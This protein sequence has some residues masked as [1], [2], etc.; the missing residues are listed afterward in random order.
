MQSA[1]KPKSF[2]FRII[3]RRYSDKS[4]IHKKLVEYFASNPT[5]KHCQVGLQKIFQ[6]LPHPKFKLEQSVVDEMESSRESL[7]PLSILK[8]SPSIRR[9]HES[10]RKSRSPSPSTGAIAKEVQR[11]QSF[12]EKEKNS[13]LTVRD[14]LNNFTTNFCQSEFNRNPYRSVNLIEFS[15]QFSAAITKERDCLAK[16]S[17]RR[18][19]TMRLKIFSKTWSS[20]TEACHTLKAKRLIAKKSNCSSTLSCTHFSKL[21]KGNK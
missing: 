16:M 13:L 2:S 1:I 8:R 15:F 11:L 9:I 17:G 12:K 7:T 6:L 18:R 5:P 3:Q 14:K 19:F 10:F 4:S 20:F 21:R